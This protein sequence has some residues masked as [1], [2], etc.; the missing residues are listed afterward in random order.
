MNK[1]LI[2]AVL[3]AATA[4]SLSASAFAAETKDPAHQVMEV[5][6]LVSTPTINITWPT[7][8]AVV[9]NPYKMKIKVTAAAGKAP[10][11]AD[12]T[13]A[14][15]KDDTVMSPEMTFSNK[16]NSDVQISV[17]GSINAYTTVD[18][19]GNPLV[20]KNGQPT[21]SLATGDEAPWDATAP[22]G[23]KD[24]DGNPILGK[25]I[26]GLTSKISIVTA[27]IKQPTWDA[28]GEKLIAG[29]T[30]NS[31]LVYVE[32]ATETKE[33]S[34]VTYSYANGYDVKNTNQMVLNTKETTKALFNVAAKTGTAQVQVRGDVAT[35]PT[36]GWDKVAKTDGVKVNLIFDASPVAPLPPKP[37]TTPAA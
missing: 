37:E 32:V 17:T 29:E 28:K 19:N 9:L 33:G 8:A 26:T 12:D 3:A 7:T 25:A 16:G 35:A 13:T 6:T 18:K 11:V 31:V 10:T 20:D 15:A 21:N 14:T 36:L 27:A 4:L 34:K 2:S 22:S 30:K 1:K 5:G 24:G 23:Q